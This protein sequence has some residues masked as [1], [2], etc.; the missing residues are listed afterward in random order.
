MLHDFKDSRTQELDHGGVTV[1]SSPDDNIGVMAIVARAIHF[2]SCKAPSDKQLRRLPGA[3]APKMNETTRLHHTS[4]CGS[5]S[6]SYL[7]RFMPQTI[8]HSLAKS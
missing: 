3:L 6:S 2:S 4:L 7:H 5:G 1:V 8:Q